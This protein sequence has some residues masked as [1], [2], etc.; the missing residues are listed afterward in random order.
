MDLLGRGIRK[1]ISAAMQKLLLPLFLILVL[2]ISLASSVGAVADKKRKPRH[3][4]SSSSSH[5]TDPEEVKR[6]QAIAF[7]RRSLTVILE[8]HKMEIAKVI[9]KDQKHDLVKKRRL[10][11]FDAY[12][13]FMVN[14]CQD[15]FDG[16]GKKASIM[17]SYKALTENIF[18]LDK[19]DFH[20][21]CL[22]SD[23]VY[24]SVVYD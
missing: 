23:V 17:R 4:S 24:P 7:L 5:S 12:D 18:L 9:A 21:S 11:M 20:N 19:T 6:D 15:E 22:T 2:I 3:R 16:Q 13:Q 8:G 1:P 10:E 14:H